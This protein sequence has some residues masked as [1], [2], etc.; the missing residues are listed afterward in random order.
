MAIQAHEALTAGDRPPGRWRRRVQRTPEPE[1][2]S[3]WSAVLSDPRP[4]RRLQG[5]IRADCAIVGAG[6]TGLAV[7]RRLAALRPDWRVV[8]L[9]ARSAGEGASARSSGFLVDLVDFV[10]RM[11]PEAR[12]RYV[13][14]AQG[15]IAELRRLVRE[16]DIDCAWDERG[17]L[18]GAAGGD[19]E[20]FLESYPPLLDELGLDYQWLD[21][22]AMEACTGSR[23][24]RAG[25]RLVGYPLVQ[26]AALVRGL[27]ASLPEGVEL[28]E[29]S[30]VESIERDGT[31]RLTVGAGGVAA[32]R[33]VLATN[34]YTPSLGFLGRKVFPLLTFG[35]L[36]RTLTPAEQRRLGGEHEWGLLAM[37]PMGS[38]VRRTRD[39]RILIRNTVHYARSLR[40]NGR[41]WPR[42]R[43]LHRRALAVRFPALADVDLEHTWTGLMGTSWSHRHWFGALEPGLY[44]SAGYT[45][46]GIAMGTA[47]GNHLAELATGG[48]S[49]GLKALLDLPSPNWMPPEPFLSLG[50]KFLATRMNRQA[51]ACL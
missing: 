50:G 27:A 45:G 40:S 2:R 8:L 41:M 24:Y 30:P 11:E 48:R 25:L 32:E 29:H 47:S 4:G 20:A 6:F 16:N 1:P 35:S 43:D 21:R 15:G 3:G 42:I 49:E 34:G 10:A 23:F 36:T 44:A 33:L 17:W 19:G 28:Y 37:D 13:A 39:Q 5:T 38:T 14:T 26:P 51:G 9:D 22:R 7:A 18:R 12:R 31:F 46:A